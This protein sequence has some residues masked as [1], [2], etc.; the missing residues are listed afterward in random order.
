MSR[1]S[2]ET[3]ALRLERSA[4]GL[5]S[6]ALD[7]ASHAALPVAVDPTFV[8]LLR[9]N[10][11]LDP[12]EA[13]PYDVEATLLTSRLF[14]ELGG[15][16]Y[17]IDEEFR[18]PLLA[19]LRARCGADRMT[20]VARLLERYNEQDNRW[21]DHRD[22]RHAQQMTVLG[23]LR[24]TVAYELLDRAERDS[25]PEVGSASEWRVA[26]R[27]RLDEVPPADIRI[28]DR[29][30]LGLRAA[31]SDV[32]DT[33]ASAG[34]FVRA[35]GLPRWF[36]PSWAEGG[37]R[38]WQEVIGRLAD[39]AVTE[40]FR[41]LL[42]RAAR[43]YSE[44]R[45]FA[46]LYR[47]YCGT[48]GTGGPECRVFSNASG[49]SARTALENMG[50][51]P[52]DDLSTDQVVSYAVASRDAE[53][54][55][56]LLDA[57]R[58]TWIAVAPPGDEQYLLRRLVVTPAGGGS[59]RLTDVPVAT[60]LGDVVGAREL[61]A[62][63]VVRVESRLG[64]TVRPAAD[65]GLGLGATGVLDGSSIT[66][67]Y[68]A[69]PLAGVEADGSPEPRHAGTLREPTGAALT[70]VTASERALTDH[71]MVVA[72][73][74]SERLT[75]KVRQRQRVELT[76]LAHSLQE[77]LDESDG[78]RPY[79]IQQPSP[80]R[81]ALVFRSLELDAALP[82][83]VRTLEARVR[84]LNIDRPDDVHIRVGLS[85]VSAGNDV[86]SAPEALSTA[87]EV[88]AGE[89]V[90]QLADETLPLVVALD[91]PA[92]GTRRPPPV[93]GR[94]WVEQDS[95]AGQIWFWPAPAPQ[96]DRIVL[97][98]SRQARPWSQRLIDKLRERDPGA[99]VTSMDPVPLRPAGEW[100][101]EIE[102]AVSRAG[103]VAL[104]LTPDVIAAAEASD[105]HRSL[106]EFAWH[107]GARVLLIP[108]GTIPRIS[109][110]DFERSESLPAD[111][112][113]HGDDVLD[114]IAATLLPPDRIGDSEAFVVVLH[115]Y[116]DRFYT[117][118]L[119]DYLAQAGVPCWGGGEEVRAATEERLR[120][121]AAV[122]AVMSPE[123]EASHWFAREIDLADER[124][125]PILPIRLRSGAVPPLLRR[126]S[127]E[128][129]GR[130][131]MPGKRFVSRLRRMTAGHE[132]EP[133]APYLV[134]PGRAT[135]AVF[136]TAARAAFTG[137]TDGLVELW[138]V[139]DCVL[140]RRWMHPGSV[141]AVCV[142]SDGAMLGVARD[143][144]RVELVDLRV[145]SDN[146]V[147][148]PI[149]EA[150][151][152]AFNSD[153][154]LLAVAEEQRG[155][156]VWDVRGRKILGPPLGG[157]SGRAQA[158]AFSPDGEYLAAGFSDHAVTVWAVPTLTGPV[159]RLISWSTRQL[160][161]AVRS[162]A[163]A[164]DSR[165]LACGTDA[166]EALVVDAASRRIAARIVVG[167]PVEV[168]TFGST[169]MTLLTGD[170]TGVVCRYD[171]P[172]G[173]RLSL[174]VGSGPV[175]AIDP[176]AALVARSEEPDL[177]TVQPLD[178]P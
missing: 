111:P 62:G 175:L 18:R 118:R 75:E 8:N 101:T 30:L 34:H 16:L 98:S 61:G 36:V 48:R 152:I 93:A 132:S 1:H 150:S 136:S 4:R 95:A 148:L 72:L 108:V 90:R 124:R 43:L 52:H 149:S 130:G 53:G 80:D 38:Y 115:A 12:P 122:I 2:E 110:L 129:V 19:R 168:V 144:N 156:E 9:V 135:V 92:F 28:T 134:L 20:R 159:D 106:L 49:D 147:T 24:P 125:K 68:H 13:L 33:E 107:V 84:T 47:R 56:D 66:L 173:A 25:G 83:V 145:M 114:A 27:A 151:G 59:H 5:S 94:G 11:F 79:E 171:I 89:A 142:S 178:R 35:L 167:G 73:R 176:L 37:D 46:R 143:R 120:D 81:I 102:D 65:L 153:A 41:H 17:E 131:S 155:V 31:L 137:T 97:L 63:V 157:S 32:F 57:G 113:E 139:P 21:K 6:A 123:A 164:P 40:G 133:S 10:F 126:L 69:G 51:Q 22:L 88:L 55:R 119:T 161:G 96:Q 99:Q 85:V 117:A 177:V 127:Y 166:G 104:F 172:T 67:A 64:E 158:V 14:R 44:Q 116:A 39:G 100:H 74:G 105:V 165:L 23:I 162:V 71:L 78:A 60:R 15:D 128:D 160:G 26:M 169:S 58:T 103:V 138:S 154:A 29:D 163:F 45:V 70:G 86:T 42:T 109:T 76:G 174:S 146:T 87:T 170:A 3:T 121:C 141:R 77:V 91:R 54:L 112:D 7:L 140:L 82:H 50:L